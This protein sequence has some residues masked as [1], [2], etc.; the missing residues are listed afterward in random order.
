MMTTLLIFPR[1]LI[2]SSSKIV[3]QFTQGTCKECRTVYKSRNIIFQ[4]K[5]RKFV[6]KSRNV[7]T[8][9]RYIFQQ[10]WS[11]VKVR[12]FVRLKKTKISGFLF[13]FSV[14]FTFGKQVFA[15][16]ASPQE[17]IDKNI[18]SN[19]FRI[20][21]KGQQSTLQ[22]LW[23]Y[24][25]L[26]LRLVE[27]SLRYTPVL[28]FLPFSYINRSFEKLWWKL[29][30]KTVEHSGPTIVKLAQWASTRRDLFSAEFCD[31]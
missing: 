31:R 27:L 16:E 12:T 30:V 5:F 23:A 11:L 15:E 13:S 7:L 9:S 6:F 10:K 20:I 24:M 14:P 3:S 22:I 4:P 19:P 18:P 28:L 25:S 21:P 26:V 8:S 1:N 2:S 29:L 17:P